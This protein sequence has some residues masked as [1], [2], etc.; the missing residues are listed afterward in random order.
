[1][2]SMNTESRT[3][4]IDAY[5][6]GKIENIASTNKTIF[7]S[8][9]DFVNETIGM[10]LNWWT[11]PQLSLSQFIELI[12]HMTD[13]MLD[14]FR[15]TLNEDGFNYLT[16]N[17]KQKRSK[18]KDLKYNPDKPGSKRFEIDVIRFDDIQDIIKQDK[19]KAKISSVQKFCD[20]ALDYFITLWTKPEKAQE[21]IFEIWPFLPNSVKKEWSKIPE[22]KDDYEN[23]SRD[24][25]EWNKKNDTGMIP[26]NDDEIKND[27]TIDS[28]KTNIKN[29]NNN[30]D[31]KSF[32]AYVRLC[33]KYEHV[34]N[35]IKKID[36][37]KKPSKIA[38]PHDH[39][40]LISSFYSR[41]FPIKISV[42]VLAQMMVEKNERVVKYDE[43]RKESYDVAV[44]ISNKI[45]EY[46]ERH[47]KKR[48]EKKSAG[49][50]YPIAGGDAAKIASSKERFREHF[51]GMKEESWIKRQEKSDEHRKDAG[52]AHFDGALNAMELAYVEVTKNKQIPTWNKDLNEYTFEK[53]GKY[54]FRIGLTEKG[55]KLY[56]DENKIFDKNS[57]GYQDEIFSQKESDFIFE[58]IIGKFELEKE[59]VDNALETVTKNS[60]NSSDKKTR[61]KKPKENSDWDGEYLDEKFET[62]ILSW[63]Q[64]HR[65]DEDKY[66]NIFNVEAI[67]NT[68]ALETIRAAIMGRLVEINKINWEIEEKTSS[69]L[70]SLPSDQT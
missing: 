70:Y 38:L 62:I 25:T 40:P 44:Y 28:Y 17:L 52:L 55:L 65:G 23:F 13:K 30:D 14:N 6:I 16:L 11:Q 36:I 57:Q 46:E 35:E 29:S 18:L 69:T 39:H 60:E 31:E 34:R 12:P 67:G 63:I 5:R 27:E 51:V 15:K 61:T 64:K 59:L 32:E 3:I 1:M 41:F 50:P 4:L 42:A 53:D 24:A 47:G 49:L 56:L 45:R 19:A 48:N 68:K 26:E 37:P 22:L 20:Y 58:N 9:E 10:Y 8:W 33:E 66:R 21:K 2:A 54:D 7:T 43:F